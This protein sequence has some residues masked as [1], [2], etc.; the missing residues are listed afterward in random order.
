MGGVCVKLFF[1]IVFIAPLTILA[2][3]RFWQYL[4][5]IAL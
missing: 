4:T 5:I 1:S 2:A 3:C